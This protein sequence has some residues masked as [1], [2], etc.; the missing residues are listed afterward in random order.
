MRASTLMKMPVISVREGVRAGAV[1]D[2]II[3]ATAPHVV[4]FTLKTDRDRAVLPFE[5]IRRIGP[6]AI[7]IDELG[8]LRREDEV[9][10]GDERRRFSALV[11]K[12]TAGDDGTYL[13]DVHDLDVDPQ[14]GSI[15]SI[16]LHR[17]GLLGLGREEVQVPGTHLHAFGA[18]LLTVAPPAVDEGAPRELAERDLPAPSQSKDSAGPGTER[19]SRMAM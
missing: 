11:G 7:V 8:V 13:G 3:L 4:A 6:D 17:G 18:K 15:E 9:E 1:A 2:L 16:R 5:S 12:E 14:T 10:Y 19:V